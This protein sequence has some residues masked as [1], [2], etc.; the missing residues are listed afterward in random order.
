MGRPGAEGYI[1][2]VLKAWGVDG[3]NSHTN[4]CSSGARFGYALWHFFDRPSPDHANA[5]FILLISAHLESG[6]YFNPHAQRIIEGM[7]K[8]A[9]LA[10][11]DPRLSNTASMADH[12]MPTYPG[13]EAA[14]LLAMAN[15]ILQDGLYDGAFIEDVGELADLPGEG[16]PGRARAPSSGS[17]RRSRRFTA[18]Y[19]PGIRRDKRAACR[20]RRSRRSPGRSAGRG[21]DSLLTTGAARAA[22]TLAAGP[23]R[24]VSTS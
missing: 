5:R 6:H 9:K 1:D 3:H 10:V 24:G 2:R 20:R 22:A 19:T 17:S 4:I 13:S 21:R 14:V 18:R 12:W 15:V 8:G 11:M 16:T 7:M 23:W